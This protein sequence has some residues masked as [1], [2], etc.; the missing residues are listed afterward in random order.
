MACNLVPVETGLIKTR[1]F[2]LAIAEPS[3]NVQYIVIAYSLQRLD[4]K[5]LLGTQ[6]NSTVDKYH[7]IR[8]GC[9]IWKFDMS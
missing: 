6:A 4:M 5:D 1:P 8:K 9:Y 3:E 7:F 2:V